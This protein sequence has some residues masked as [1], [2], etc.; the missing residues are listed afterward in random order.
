MQCSLERQCDTS[1][2]ILILSLGVVLLPWCCIV[3]MVLLYHS[4]AHPLGSFETGPMLFVQP[5]HTTSPD[6]VPESCDAWFLWQP[7]AIRT[8]PFTC[9]QEVMCPE[10]ERE[11]EGQKVEEEARK[12]LSKASL[13]QDGECNS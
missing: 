7:E 11:E 13:C 12:L 1:S 4:P 2:P 3:V 10:Q 8:S 9:V 5:V 6:K